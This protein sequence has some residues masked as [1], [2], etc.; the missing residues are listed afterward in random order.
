MDGHYNIYYGIVKWAQTNQSKYYIDLKLKQK[1]DVNQTCQS[2]ALKK[3]LMK[4]D[5]WERSDGAI[6]WR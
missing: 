2:H 5:M 6:Y 4:S 3:G 1:F